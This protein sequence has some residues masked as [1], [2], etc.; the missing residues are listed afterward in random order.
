MTKDKKRPAV[1]ERF[2]ASGGVCPQAVL[3]EFG[4]LSPARTFVNPRL[5]QA[6]TTLAEMRGR[7]FDDNLLTKA[8]D[9]E[10]KWTK[11]N[12]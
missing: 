4:S 5:R 10:R 7:Q 12:I 8:E 1:N 11:K 6:A 3:W 9:D 2:H